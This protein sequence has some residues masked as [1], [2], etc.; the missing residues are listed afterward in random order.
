FAFAATARAVADHH[1]DLVYD[2][3]LGDP[4]VRAFLIDNNPA[5]ARE[6]AERLIE[7]QERGLWKTRSNAGR[8]LLE[9]LAEGNLEAA[10]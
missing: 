9:E 4:D 3:Y 1:F 6:I 7:A 10:S 8:A 2:A 5:A